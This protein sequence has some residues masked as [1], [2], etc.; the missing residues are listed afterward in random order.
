MAICDR[1][2]DDANSRTGTISAKATLGRLGVATRNAVAQ[3]SHCSE[4]RNGSLQ[5]DLGSLLNENY[6]GT[7]FY[8]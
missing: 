6:R 4:E 5:S 3:F 7:D 8:L 1:A 2:K